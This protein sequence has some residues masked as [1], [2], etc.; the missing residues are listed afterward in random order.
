M[1]LN[2]VSKMEVRRELRGRVEALSSEAKAK[3]S[4][5]IVER[6][7]SLLED[8]SATNSEFSCA[9]F[10]GLDTEPNLRALYN[11]SAIDWAYP[12]LSGNTL[13]FAKPGKSFTKNSFQIDEPTGADVEVGS[14]QAVLV[15]GVGFDENLNRLGRGKGYYDRALQ[16]YWGLKIGICF[17]EQFLNR[18]PST[19]DHDVPVDYIVTDSFIYK[20]VEKAKQ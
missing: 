11:G 12:K 2:L 18:L 4:T 1:N 5:A 9:G 14:L 15:P 3:K 7:R 16:N 6:L 19:E 13:T 17:S 10:L 20:A 8:L